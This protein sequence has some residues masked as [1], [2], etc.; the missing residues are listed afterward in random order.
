MGQQKRPFIYERTDSM[1]I[2]NGHEIAKV[3]LGLPP[4]KDSSLHAFS[5][6]MPAF[7]KSHKM[8]VLDLSIFEQCER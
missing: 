8:A 5:N 1:R 2:K 7:T 4:Q 6:E 3:I